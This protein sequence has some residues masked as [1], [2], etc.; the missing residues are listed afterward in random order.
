MA[1]TPSAAKESAAERAAKET[2]AHFDFHG[3]EPVKVEDRDSTPI[4]QFWIWVGSNTAPINWILGALGIAFGLSFIQ[5]IVVIIIGNIVGCTIFGLCAVMGHRTGVNQLTLSRLAFGRRGAYLPAAM[6][7]LATIG[8]TG[9]YTWLVL[10]LTLGIL[11]QLGVHGSTG[12]KYGLA[13]GIMIIQLAIAFW[14]FYLIRSFEKYTVPVAAAIFAVMTVL[15]I[16]HTGIDFNTSKAHGGSETFTAITQLMTA[17]GIGWSISWVTWGSDY[18]RFVKPRYSDKS[19]VL[20][21]ALGMFVPTVWLAALGAAVAS[22]GSS[23]DPAQLVVDVFGVMSIPVLIA[24]LHGTIGNN[25]IN[26][27]SSSMSLLSLDAKIARWKT[28]LAVGVVAMGVVIWFIASSNFAQSFN[29]WITSLVV[30]LSPWA[31]IT[32]VDYLGFRRGKV[33][34]SEL[35]RPPSRK[36]LP[37]INVPGIIAFVVGTAAGW[38]FEYGLVPAFQG[39]IAKATGNVDLSWLFGGVVAGLLYFVLCKAMGRTPKPAAT[40]AVTDSEPEIHPTKEMA[41]VGSREA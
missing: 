22:S 6:Q 31:A 5:T 17:I 7:L 37:D 39:P 35:Y 23:T 14:G 29:E 3:I 1:T 16:V 10:D 28:T 13:I 4:Q 12:L 24:V 41:R 20:S 32:L 9:V 40:P 25:I 34:V 27:Y 18:T 21:T 15:A 26:L 38:S 11:D 33:D 8:W 36:L 30:W 2:A 19:V